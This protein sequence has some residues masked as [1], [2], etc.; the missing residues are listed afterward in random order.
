MT[1]SISKA[2]AIFLIYLFIV[3]TAFFILSKP[4]DSLFDSFDNNDMGEAN[5]ELDMVMPNIRIAFTIAFA[6]MFAA[7][8]TWF[9]VWVVHREP[10]TYSRRY[11]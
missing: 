7:P 3:I 1:D 11:R 9:I 4:V 2:G 8:I 5:D 10:A 6:L